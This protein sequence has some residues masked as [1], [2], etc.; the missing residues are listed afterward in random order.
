MV[1]IVCNNYALIE[2]ILPFCIT[3]YKQKYCN[4]RCNNTETKGNNTYLSN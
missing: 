4:L 1:G 2:K 3:L